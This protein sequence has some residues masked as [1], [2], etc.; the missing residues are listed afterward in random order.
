M[1]VH[2]ACFFIARA[3]RA[4]TP[5]RNRSGN[6]PPILCI[7]PLV[8]HQLASARINCRHR[9][10]VKVRCGRPDA[11]ERRGLI[12]AA[13]QAMIGLSRG[14]V[15]AGDPALEVMRHA[16]RGEGVRQGGI[17]ADHLEWYELVGVAVLGA[18]GAVAP[19]A[20]VLEDGLALL[21][22]GPIDRVRIAWRLQAQQIGADIGELWL[23]LLDRLR[24]GAEN[25]EKRHERADRPAVGGTQ[26]VDRLLFPE[27]PPCGN[28]L[29]KVL[30]E[31]ILDR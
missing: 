24:A 23:A 22:Q 21:S 11:V 2:R 30:A 13:A 3:G 7:L 16:F 9:A 5:E 25:Q 14:T 27:M 19:N 18:V 29:A 20:G 31:R 1:G 28:V 17:G 6:Q 26:M 15:L 10:V 4:A 12:A 8:A